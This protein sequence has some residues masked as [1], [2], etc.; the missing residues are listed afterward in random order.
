[1]SG[2]AHATIMSRE[3]GSGKGWLGKRAGSVKSDSREKRRSRRCPLA[4]PPSPM[5]CACAMYVERKSVRGATNGGEE[6]VGGKT[7]GRK[8]TFSGQSSTRRRGEPLVARR[9]QRPCVRAPLD[10]REREEERG[11]ARCRRG[12]FLRGNAPVKQ[13]LRRGMALCDVR[14]RV[15]ERQRRPS[16][17]LVLGA[18]KTCFVCFRHCGALGAGLV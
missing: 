14:V 1:M 13:P 11:T 18:R 8:K 6:R 10:G 2:Q 4:P 5:V 9:R 12:F 15:G 17:S 3:A 7:L 16:S